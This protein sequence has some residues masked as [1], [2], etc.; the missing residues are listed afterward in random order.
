MGSSCDAI[1]C[2]RYSMLH[3]LLFV[4]DLAQQLQYHLLLL[5]NFYDLFWHLIILEIDNSCFVI[6]QLRM[7]SVFYYLCKIV[8][9]GEWSEDTPKHDS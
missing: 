9:I 5:V 4:L 2:F 8:T 7:P 1:F 3:L 6:A